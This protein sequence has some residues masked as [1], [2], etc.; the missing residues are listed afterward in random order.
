ME[1]GI[2]RME[3]M[4]FLIELEVDFSL[5]KSNQEPSLRMKYPQRRKIRLELHLFSF[6]Q[7]KFIKSFRLR[8][9]VSVGVPLELKL[10]LPLLFSLKKIDYIPFAD[11]LT[12]AIHPVYLRTPTA[13]GK[14]RGGARRREEENG[15]EEILR[16]EVVEFA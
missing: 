4:R 11:T 8:Q 7:A 10:L 15:R 14:G 6:I 3:L 12:S 16:S 13:K 5:T 2:A 1:V 9:S